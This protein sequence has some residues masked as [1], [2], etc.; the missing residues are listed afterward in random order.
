MHT[1]RS[2]IHSTFEQCALLFFWRRI[3]RTA[4]TGARG[5]TAHTPETKATDQ[6]HNNSISFSEK[7]SGITVSLLDINGE[8]ATKDRE[9]LTGQQSSQ[10]D[11]TKIPW[12]MTCYTLMYFQFGKV[13][14]SLWMKYAPDSPVLF[15]SGPTFYLGYFIL[16]HALRRRL[17]D[18][19]RP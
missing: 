13:L 19:V 5:I 7:L 6:T 12:V 17:K 9:I 15:L 14:P 8:T 18:S 3:N 4:A 16:E 11:M 1:K 10:Q 2:K